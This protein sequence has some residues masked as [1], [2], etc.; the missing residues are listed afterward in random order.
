M[1]HIHVKGPYLRKNI[2]ESPRKDASFCY[3]FVK[4]RKV[5]K[6][7]KTQGVGGDIKA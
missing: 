4:I 1:T 2:Q 6:T 3:T 5:D 7:L